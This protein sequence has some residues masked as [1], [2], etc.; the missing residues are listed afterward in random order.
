MSLLCY[1][2]VG[3]N[4]VKILP[5]YRKASYYIPFAPYSYT[6]PLR[7]GFGCICTTRLRL[8]FL[9]SHI[10]RASCNSHL[11]VLKLQKLQEKYINAI[12]VNLEMFRSDVLGTCPDSKTEKRWNIN[13]VINY[14]DYLGLKNLL[15]KVVTMELTRSSGRQNKK[16]N[17]GKWQLEE[18]QKKNGE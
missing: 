12:T 3:Q 1:C 2:C 7:P 18:W 4:K 13:E 5:L 17:Y 9:N 10:L 14:T 15:I 8:S 16:Q 11:M 6:K